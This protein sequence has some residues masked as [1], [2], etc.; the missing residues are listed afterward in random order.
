MRGCSLPIALLPGAEQVAGAE[1]L[2]AAGASPIDP[3]NHQPREDEQAEF[4]IGVAGRRGLPGAGFESQRA[5]SAG[6]AGAL[7]QIGADPQGEAGIGT[8][9]L[10]DS[11]WRLAA[12]RRLEDGENA[13]RVPWRRLGLGGAAAHRPQRGGLRAPACLAPH[14]PPTTGRAV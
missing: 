6:S 3:A 1:E 10:N 2:G 11:L 5:G 7:A 12:R 4:A 8:Q 14:F 13:R 9:D